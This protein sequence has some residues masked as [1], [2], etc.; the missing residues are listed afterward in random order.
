MPES[1]FKTFM[2][3]MNIHAVMDTI[4]Q[5]DEEGIDFLYLYPMSPY[6]L[7]EMKAS[8]AS[9]AEVGYWVIGKAR[10]GEDKRVILDS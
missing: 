2:S 6:D 7:E 9:P 3:P 8:G 1:K 5:M 10:E 4:S